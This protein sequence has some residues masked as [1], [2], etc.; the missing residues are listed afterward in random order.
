MSYTRDIFWEKLRNE[1]IEEYAE[2]LAI[3]KAVNTMIKT[4]I[5]FNASREKTIEMVCSEFPQFSKEEISEHV[6]ELWDKQNR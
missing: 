5:M 2:E 6:S 4:C 3:K 1:K